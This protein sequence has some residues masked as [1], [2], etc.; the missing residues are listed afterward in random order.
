MLVHLIL[1]FKNWSFQHFL[2][3]VLGLPGFFVANYRGF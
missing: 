3:V 1:Y 2:M